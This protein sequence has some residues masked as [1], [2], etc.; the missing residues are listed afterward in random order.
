MT[1]ALDRKT[2]DLYLLICSSKCSSTRDLKIKEKC[3]NFRRIAQSEFY[4]KA[5]Q[6][7]SKSVRSF[8]NLILLNPLRLNF[9]Y[10]AAFVA[11]LIK[12]AL[13]NN[14][15]MWI[16][17]LR[18]CGGTRVDEIQSPRWLTDLCLVLDNISSIISL[19]NSRYV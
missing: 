19:K 4:I 8:R 10:V 15:A 13:H 17:N 9:V 11:S 6:S 7:W 14:H 18:I 3:G 16:L 5:N 12:L 1:T 2:F